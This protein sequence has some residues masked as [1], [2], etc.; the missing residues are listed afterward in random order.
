MDP[1]GI[2]SHFK[3][4]V[5]EESASK[6]NNEKAPL[7]NIMRNYELCSRVI[8]DNSAQLKQKINV[9]STNEIQL[10]TAAQLS[11]ESGIFDRFKH[12]KGSKHVHAPEILKHYIHKQT[13]FNNVW[14]ALLKSALNGVCALKAPSSV[15]LRKYPSSLPFLMK[16]QISWRC[17]APKFRHPIALID[18]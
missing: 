6:R 17:V 8:G 18:Q 14:T 2:D 10:E 7:T 11:P 3:K 4:Q 15:S 9:A 1:T 5:D 12:A 13:S 16:F